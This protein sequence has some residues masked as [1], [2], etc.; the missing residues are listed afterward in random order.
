MSID[1]FDYN[2]INDDDDYT[3]TNR[4]IDVDELDS[5]TWESDLPVNDRY[6]E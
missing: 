4:I 5:E 6:E 3:G 1:D 2:D